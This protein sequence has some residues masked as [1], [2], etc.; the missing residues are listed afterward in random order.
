MTT[1]LIIYQ[2]PHDLFALLRGPWTIKTTY[3]KSV[4]TGTDS[5][6]PKSYSLLYNG[7]LQRRIPAH[8][9]HAFMTPELGRMIRECCHLNRANLSPRPLIQ[10]AADAPNPH[11]HLAKL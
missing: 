9:R 8:A 3:H 7:K 1:S 2:A 11:A 6:V 10:C 4:S 5:R